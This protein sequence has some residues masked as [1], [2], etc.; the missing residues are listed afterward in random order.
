MIKIISARMVK[1]KE[2]AIAYRPENALLDVN[3]KWL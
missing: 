3:I 2:S 1:G